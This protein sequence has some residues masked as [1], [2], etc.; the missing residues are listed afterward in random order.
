MN[1]GKR[2]DFYLRRMPAFIGQ[3]LKKTYQPQ[4]QLLPMTDT[5]RMTIP[6]RKV[7][8]R[9]HDFKEIELPSSKEELRKE[10]LRCLTCPLRYRQ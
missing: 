5:N 3:L 10:A 1:I 7:E 8:E 9:K 4:L 2:I 6:H